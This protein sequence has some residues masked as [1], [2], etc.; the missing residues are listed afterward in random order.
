MQISLHCSAAGG[1]RVKWNTTNQHL[2]IKRMLL[3][4][5]IRL[6]SVNML[7]RNLTVSQTQKQYMYDPRHTPILH[8]VRKILCN[9]EYS[10]QPTKVITGIIEKLVKERTLLIFWKENLQI[11]SWRGPHVSWSWVWTAKIISV[12]CQF[13]LCS[14][15]WAP[16]SLYLLKRTQGW[17]SS[18][19]KIL[20]WCCCSS[21]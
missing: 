8:Y 1:E 19:K 14:N 16:W 2:W 20:C 13:D 17:E 3:H 15:W 9:S 5:M 11:K 21:Y 4:S 7:L 18:M 10:R 6:I 12:S